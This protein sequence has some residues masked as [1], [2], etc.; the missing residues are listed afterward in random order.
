MHLKIDLYKNPV[1]LNLTLHQL[2]EL[3]LVISNSI[4]ERF[5]NKIPPALAD[6]KNKIQTHLATICWYLNHINGF[7]AKNGPS[8]TLIN[9]I[10][11]IIVCENIITRSPLVSNFDQNDS[12][13]DI[14]VYILINLWHTVME[15][16][17]GTIL[18]LH[19]ADV[20]QLRMV[21]NFKA[22][23]KTMMSDFIRMC[24]GLFMNV[25]CQFI[26]DFLTIDIDVQEIAHARESLV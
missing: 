25:P 6:V 9:N 13:L 14:N 15:S 21:A 24:G 7:K 16:G 4:L 22:M 17:I 18:M 2:T 23:V 3:C 19:L 20:H 12:S 11:A 10:K 1:V 26:L 5:A 8:Y